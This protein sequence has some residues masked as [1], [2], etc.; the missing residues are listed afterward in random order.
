MNDEQS[1]LSAEYQKQAAERLRINLRH[2][3]NGVSFADPNTAYIDARARIGKGSFIGPCTVIE[4]ET[5][6]GEDC[7]IGQNTRICDSLV[8]NGARIEQSVVIE[9]EIG[10]RARV[11]PFAYLR[12]GSRIGADAKVGDFVEV[13]NS[14]L[15]A[16]SKASHLT[17]IG[18]ADIG[19]DVNLGCG[20]VFVNFD[21]SEKH[22]SVV[23][24]GAFIGCNVNI[25]SP[26][27]VGDGAYVAAGTTITKDLPAGAL[28]VGR[29]KQRVLEGW[30]RR[31]G[32]IKSR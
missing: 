31:R 10:D 3:E 2:A 14:S 4:G 30:V 9:S 19:T 6:I 8:G 18:D 7:F 24:D 28:A 12:P 16:G 22:R 13:K 1:A 27:V 11:G 29:A 20:V 26:V 32:L 25:V 15:G 17:Y 5:G 23:G 21:G